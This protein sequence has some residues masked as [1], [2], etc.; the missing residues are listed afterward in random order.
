MMMYCMQVVN[1]PELLK[2]IKE[3]AL[4]IAVKDARQDAQVNALSTISAQLAAQQSEGHLG[5]CR[6]S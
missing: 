5:Q 1:L 6:R 3:R 4:E 2:P